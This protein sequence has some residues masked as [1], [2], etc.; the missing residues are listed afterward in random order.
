MDRRVFERI[1]KRLADKADECER[2]RDA[3]PKEGHGIMF[4]FLDGQVGGFRLGAQMVL[5]AFYEESNARANNT[6]PAAGTEVPAA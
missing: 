3:L 1:S 2:R 4:N 6:M 5:E